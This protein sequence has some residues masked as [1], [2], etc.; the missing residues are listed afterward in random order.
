MNPDLKREEEVPSYKG[1]DIPYRA[2]YGVL[3]VVLAITV[4]YAIVVWPMVM[5]FVGLTD[6]Q[7]AADVGPAVDASR[8]A[9]ALLQQYPE[10]EYQAFAAQQQHAVESYGWKD[11]SAGIARVPLER[12]KELTLHQGLGPIAAPDTAD[13]SSE[14]APEAPVEQ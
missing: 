4:V 2:L 13:E 12:A 7:E 8:P 11:E 6:R 14:T 3:L 5:G 1:F 9:G 10:L